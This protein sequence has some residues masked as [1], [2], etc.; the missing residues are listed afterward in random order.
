LIKFFFRAPLAF[1][2]RMS[3]PRPLQHGPPSLADIPRLRP[4]NARWLILGLAC[5]AS[6]L[7]YVHRYSWGATRPFFKA[8][9]GLTDQDMGWLD[10]AFN[11]TYALGQFPG[12]WAGDVFGPRMVIPIAVV[13]WSIVMIG[14]ALTGNFWGLLAARLGFGGTQAPCYPNLGKITKSWFPLRIRTSMQ[15]LVA[16]FA[17]RAGGA[18]AP[19]IIGTVLMASMGLSWQTALYALASVGLLFAIG[20]WFLFRDTPAEHPWSNADEQT[21]VEAG[22]VAA[23]DGPAA[24]HPS[25]VAAQDGPAATHPSGVAA[26][27]GSRRIRWTAANVANLAVF[28]AASFCSSFADNLFVFYMPQFLVEEKGFTAEQMGMFAGLPILG[29]AIGGM[30][31]GILNDVLIR[32]TGNRRLSRSL[33][34]S[35]GKVVAAVLIAASLLVA[36]GRMVMFVLFFCKFF[37]DWSQPTWWGTVT[38]IGGP[39]S[40]RVFGMVNTVG[41]IGATA[42]GPVMGYVLGGHGWT[43]LFLFVGGVYVLTAICWVCVNCTRRVVEP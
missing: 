29:G 6:F 27:S 20:F 43:A 39:A 35:S 3:E 1:A 36:D 12:G 21:L 13:L 38:D 11:L 15:G 42:A 37:S 33:V 41:S 4:S 25:G 10:G 23:Q 34:A 17:G 14:P 26:Q 2:L 19:L 24:T 30:C 31:G 9:Y 40:G 22:E 8:E 16:S 18:A 7:T 32:A 28:M 5:F